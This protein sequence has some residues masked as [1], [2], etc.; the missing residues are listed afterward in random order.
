MNIFKQL[1]K[2]IYSPKDISIFRFQGIGKTILY[3]FLLTLISIIPSMYFL[4]TAITEGVHS[5][6]ET[7][8]SKLPDFQI[9]NGKL[10]SDSNKPLTITENGFVMVFDSSGEAKASDLDQVENGVALLKNELV[11]VA[12][13]DTQSYSYSMLEDLTLNK[14]DL[15]NLIDS[16][17]SS[18][19]I[20]LPILILANYILSLGVKFIEISILAAL[21]LIIKNI[22]LRKLNYGQ[23]WRMSAYSVTLTT[24]F[25]TVMAALK[26]SVPGDF[27]LNWMVSYFVLFLA[28]KEIPQAKK[29]E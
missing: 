17:D 5:A 23:L 2:S 27:L 8:A 28:V 7:V 4:S 14:K 22:T 11:F 1:V 20:F 25:F 12:N 21:G 13:G 29:S 16:I 3:V 26:T 6:K 24:I 18:L 9:N 19:V 10:E 15:V